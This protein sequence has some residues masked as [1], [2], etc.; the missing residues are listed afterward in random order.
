MVDEKNLKEIIAYVKSELDK[1]KDVEDENVKSVVE[2]LNT[3]INDIKIEAEEVSEEKDDDV[4]EE[5]DEDEESE[6]DEDVKEKVKEDVE[7]AT[8]EKTEEV[9]E[10]VVEETEAEEVVEETTNKELSKEVAIKLKEAAIELSRFE[11]ELKAKEEI[12]G[13]YKNKVLELEKELDVYKVAKVDADTKRFKGKADKLVELYAKLGITK[14]F[15]EIELSF[16]EEQVDKLIKDLEVLK[17]PTTSVRKTV[18]SGLELSN[19]YITKQDQNKKEMS[20]A[21]TAKVLFGL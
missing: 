2:G 4:T 21:D 19:N 3:Y 16:N 5:S 9:K 7:E 15:K 11:T 18:T 14:E 8:E 1:I 17:K 6:E 20:G 13:G 12:I 10:E